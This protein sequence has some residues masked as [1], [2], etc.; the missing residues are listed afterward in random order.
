MLL[1]LLNLQSLMNEKPY[2]NEPGFKTE[3][4]KGAV[5]KY[6][7]YLRHET[8]RVAVA[9]MLEA[10]QARNMPKPLRQVRAGV[11][12]GGV[13]QS[14]CFCYTWFRFTTPWRSYKV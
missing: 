6:N 9:D 4:S 14:S 13:Y 2:H 12:G 11:V 1:L 8:L 3:R 10:R 5:H 7:L